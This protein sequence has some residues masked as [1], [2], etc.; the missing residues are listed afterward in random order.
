MQSTAE[1]IPDSDDVSRL[2][3]EPSMR[4][5]Q[6]IIWSN[7]FQFPSDGGQVESVVWRKYAAAIDDVHALGC[8]VQS[9]MRE[10][11]R[12][13]TYIGAITG[14]VG[15]IRSLK[16][17]NGVSFTVVHHPPEGQ[18]HAHIGFTAGSGKS[19]RNSLKVRLR[20]VFGGIEGYKST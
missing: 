2:L 1:E 10:K 19:D 12:S 6:D 11:G 8:N 20:S 7:V 9:T 14:N 13:S 5:D 4:V 15:A 16:S 17:P 3:F 18:A